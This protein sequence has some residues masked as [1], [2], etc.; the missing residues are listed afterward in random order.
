[1]TDTIKSVTTCPTCGGECEV[2]GDTTHY[3]ISLTEQLRKEKDEALR[4]LNDAIKLI[5]SLP[6]LLHDSLGETIEGNDYE[7]IS[8]YGKRYI[9]HKETGCGR[10]LKQWIKSEI[11]K[12]LK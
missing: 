1:M 4:L 2:K 9:S 6:D 12:A 10:P 5:H 7:I 11:N 3:Y 8:C